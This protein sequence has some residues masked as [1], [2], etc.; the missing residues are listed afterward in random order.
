MKR[1]IL[2]PFFW[3]AFSLATMAQEEFPYP[4]VPAEL[5][6][7]EERAN[8]V[9]R[10]YW[11]GIDYADTTLIHHSNMLEQ[12]FVNFI[13]LLPRLNSTLELLG[14]TTFAEKALG[15]TPAYNLY[16]KNLAERYL[17][18]AT[19]PMRNDT[20]YSHLL[21][22]INALPTTSETEKE[23]NRFLI[24]SLNKNKVGSIATDF[25]YTDAHGKKHRLSDVNT[26]Y[27]IVFFYDPDC[28]TCHEVEKQMEEESLLKE[29]LTPSDRPQKVTLIK[30]NAM[31]RKD[32]W[33]DYYFR[34]FPTLY[35]LDSHCRVLQK[36]TTLG[37]I[38]S[39]FR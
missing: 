18:T 17:Y 13:D 1:L 16:L 28:E 31:E 11:D 5:T 25:E 22:A 10:H 21:E 37:N 7:L 30:A 3:M 9:V 23:Q 26:P 20:L 24:S 27:I 33:R 2:L 36:D 12:G 6:S 4:T 34:S 14:L 19:S 8:Y 29:C 38:L 15:K 39:T 32:L 35:L